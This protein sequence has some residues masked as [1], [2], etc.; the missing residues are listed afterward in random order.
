MPGRGAFIK[1]LRVEAARFL[2]EDLRGALKGQDSMR[3]RTYVPHY[4][5]YYVP[6]KSPLSQQHI[7]E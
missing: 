3:F 1:R 4:L 7:T 2:T 5:V 6:F